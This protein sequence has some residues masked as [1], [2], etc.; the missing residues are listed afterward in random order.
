MP[1][2]ELMGGGGQKP[3][4]R[5]REPNVELEAHPLRSAPYSVQCQPS[6]ILATEQ[7]QS[8]PDELI[9]LG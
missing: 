4:R 5:G 1:A 7:R 2:V 8:D 3:V 6:R 9:A